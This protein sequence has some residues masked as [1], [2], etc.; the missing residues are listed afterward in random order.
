MKTINI[1]RVV[2]EGKEE[3][4]LLN[5]DNVYFFYDNGNT[6]YIRCG[7][8]I[9]SCK[10]DSEEIFNKITSKWV[11]ILL[12]LHIGGY[13]IYFNTDKIKYFNHGVNEASLVHLGDMAV[14]V[15]EE[16]YAVQDEINH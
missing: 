13:P 16:L 6:T 10:D 4:I 11:G 14:G 9:L 5:I 12:G 1:K 15:D 3:D 2:D 8:E 7:D